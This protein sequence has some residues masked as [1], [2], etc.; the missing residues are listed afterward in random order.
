MGKNSSQQRSKA[1]A[2]PYAG[3]TI[4]KQNPVIGM[5]K[6]MILV[7]ESMAMNCTSCSVSDGVSFFN[8]V[9]TEGCSSAGSEGGPS[10]FISRPRFK[11]WTSEPADCRHIVCQLDSFQDWEWDRS[12]KIL[13]KCDRIGCAWGW[14][15][16]GGHVW[17]LI[18][19]LRRQWSDCRGREAAELKSIYCTVQ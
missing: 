3:W 1:K 14:G 5:W 16:W 4:D 8:V 12:Y 19:G 2:L 7:S 11:P 17:W 18:R 15:W 9:W 6:E 10:G 13:T